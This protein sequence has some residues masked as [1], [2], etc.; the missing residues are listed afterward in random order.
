MEFK[1]KII[2]YCKYYEKKKCIIVNLVS[3]VI[4]YLKK[5]WFCKLRN[6]G[7]FYY[8]IKSIIE[9]KGYLIVER[10][11]IIEKDLNEFFFCFYWMFFLMLE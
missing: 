11:L 3:W 6:M 7:D 5:I 10:W 4:G 9:N 1:M 8:N 2:N